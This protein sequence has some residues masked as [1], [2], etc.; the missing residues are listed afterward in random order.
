MP[1]FD[2]TG[3]QSDPMAALDYLS[4]FSGG[5]AEIG[6]SLIG[7]GLGG[8]PGT[9]FPLPGGPAT[10]LPGG[11]IT[12]GGT[13][14]GGRLINPT[15]NHPAATHPGQVPHGRFASVIYPVSLST[16]S[17]TPPTTNW[18]A[19][20]SA[21][22]LFAYT[23]ATTSQ[24]RARLK[25]P[26]GS[27]VDF[28]SAFTMPVGN[29][30]WSIWHVT[31]FTDAWG[32]T[33]SYEYDPTYQYLTKIHYPSGMVEKWSWDENAGG[34]TLSRITVTYDLDGDNVFDEAGNEA[35]MRWGMEFA[36]QGQLTRPFLS[37]PLTR[38]FYP[39]SPYVTA[40]SQNE[41]FSTTPVTEHRVIELA[42]DDFGTGNPRLTTVYEYWRGTLFGSSA[43][44]SDKIATITCTSINGRL[45]VTD[46]LDRHG[47]HTTYNY[48]SW[49]S[50]QAV[51]EAQVTDPRGT[52]RTIQFDA[53]AR[54]T[55]ETITPG[56]TAS[57]R[58]RYF[59]SYFASL[60]LSEPSSVYWE[61]VYGS[62]GC[63]CGKPTEVR[64]PGVN[65]QRIE[66]WTWDAWGYPLTHTYPNPA[67]ASSASTI[68]ES[69]T[70]DR[71]VD[72]SSPLHSR[73]MMATHTDPRGTWTGTTTW[74]T[75]PGTTQQRPSA[76]VLTSPSVHSVD[77]TT[78]TVA[79]SIA[80][81]SAGR[82]TRTVD[83]DGVAVEYDYL[84]NNQDPGTGKPSTITRLPDGQTGPSVVT[85]FTWDNLG[86]LIDRIDNAGSS[87]ER[88]STFEH[89]V[90][91]RLLASQ[92]V[93]SDV[94]PFGGQHS[95]IH[96]VE[97]LRDRHGNVAVQR[98]RSRNSSDGA[99]HRDGGSATS[100]AREWIRHDRHFDG[101]WLVTEFVD[102]RALDLDANG[103][104]SDAPDALTLEYSYTHYPDGTIA[105]VGLPNGAV[106]V[107]EVDGFGT[108]FRTST[109]NQSA[110]VT[111]AAYMIDSALDVIKAYRGKDS[112]GLNLWT[113][114]NRQPWSGEIDSVVEP[115]LPNAP[116]GYTGSLG[117]ASHVFTRDTLGRTTAEETYDGSTLLA[118][119]EHEYDELSRERRT[120]RHMLGAGPGGYYET[121]RR[122]DGASLLASVEQP[123]GRLTSY[124]YDDLG[125]LNEVDDSLQPTAN[126]LF[127]DYIAGTD[128]ISM[129]RARLVHDVLNGSATTVEYQTRYT[130]D[131]L[132]RLRKIEELGAGGANPP[133][134][135]AFWYYTTGDTE[136]HL[137]WKG[138][139]QPAVGSSGCR[140]EHYLPDALG[141]LVEQAILGTSSQST[142][143]D[144]VLGLVHSDWTD[145]ST[146]RTRLDRYDGVG[147]RTTVHY[148]F[149]GRADIEQRPGAPS[150]LPTAVSQE[151]TLVA[152]Y[153]AASRIASLKHGYPIS[154][155]MPTTEMFWSGSD[156]L[157]V[158]QFPNVN[159]FP[160][161][162]FMA[163]REV[164]DR[165]ARGRVTKASTYTGDLGSLA[166]LD[167]VTMD[168]D[169]VGRVHAEHY[170]FGILDLSATDIWNVT[171]TYDATLKDRRDSLTYQ[172]GLQMTMRWDA[173]G[174][175]EGLDW[176]PGGSSQL[177][178]DYGHFGSQTS[179]RHL[180]PKDGATG[181]FIDTEYAF[182][183]YGRMSRIT[184]S[185][186]GSN[187]AQIDD[188]Q[189][190][191]DNFGN[192][193]QELYN[194]PDGNPNT[195]NAGDEFH[196]DRFHRLQEAI[197]GASAIP[198][199]PGTDTF[200][201]KLTYGLDPAGNRTTVQ[202]QNGGGSPSTETYTTVANRYTQVQPTIPSTLLYDGRGNLIFDGTHYYVFDFKDRL[203]E[204]WQLV[205][206]EVPAEQ[207][208]LNSAQAFEPLTA[209]TALLSAAPL[210]SAR[211]TVLA[212][213]QAT[214]R[215]N[216]DVRR[217]QA[218]GVLTEPVLLPYGTPIQTSAGIRYSQQTSTQ[219]TSLQ[220]IAL[221]GY[222]AY[223]RRV[224][225]LVVSDSTTY[226]HVYDGWREIQ[227]LKV[228]GTTGAK[229]QFK[230]FVWGS[231]L[232]E[233]TAY[234]RNDAPQGQSP[235]WTTY[236]TTQCGHECALSVLSADGTLLE[237]VTFDPYGTASIFSA[238]GQYVGAD[239]ATLL[240]FL[241]KA[242]HNE[243]EAPLTLLRNR[244]YIPSIGRFAS[245]D[246]LGLWFDSTNR[247]SGYAYGGNSPVVFTDPFGLQGTATEFKKAYDKAVSS[248]EIDPNEEMSLDKL[249]VLLHRHKPK[250][251]ILDD[252]GDAIRLQQVKWELEV[253]H[254][255]KWIGGPYGAVF[256]GGELCAKAIKE[257]DKPGEVA[258]TVGFFAAI[259]V[260]MH[261]M[262]ESGDG[263]QID[264]S[265]PQDGRTTDDPSDSGT[266]SSDGEQ[267]GGM[268]GEGGPTIQSKTMGEGD[269]WRIDVENP[270]PG[271]RPGQVHI[272]TGKDKWLYEPALDLFRDKN[273]V[274]APSRI[275]RLLQ[276][277]EIRRAINKALKYLGGG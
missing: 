205:A 154:G 195:T 106:R 87:L 259:W 57:E 9:S 188:Y 52:V 139:S 266:S 64:S 238:T 138:T 71:Q 26:T 38:I 140:E 54:K 86:R 73:S 246:P 122:F 198:F 201:Q 11:I 217:M 231:R 101:D 262:V 248:G 92:A 153:D 76:Y 78:S 79:T 47:Y 170:D 94:D 70:W 245:V 166:L 123:G 227:E 55:R 163:S 176:N 41:L 241:W 91:G 127:Y 45:R 50:N 95:I 128:S 149:A 212:G 46:L 193:S 223:N 90:F 124:K 209:K 177:L 81:N 242:A 187:P 16:T 98:E 161:H 112:A 199:T 167:A 116:P 104:L 204:I 56:S 61:Y 211:E 10:G 252:P 129:R 197:L 224:G 175:M 156:Q 125:R 218:N 51:A 3:V 249:S 215:V 121:K 49:N 31:G 34:G 230:E 206:D 102:R 222:D 186:V 221:Y 93:V 62:P 251:G 103:T 89:D 152:A 65:G 13:G 173:I 120:K 254:W 268:L 19:E 59:D 160:Y 5:A 169:S 164:F 182:E 202:T 210:H 274:R 151:N 17:G 219:T 60:G 99:P 264:G 72:S 276:D 111:D 146:C 225:R 165:D 226:L 158:R 22:Q 82:V 67:S 220:L 200:V 179:W 29:D 137:N 74:T 132:G 4:V 148:D 85:K 168:E 213:L 229:S 105:Q 216:Q 162:S 36:H 18:I 109:V 235:S 257:H 263:P 185:R 181:T 155:V 233:L 232:D 255:A 114:I 237:R 133:E 6:T 110:T 1:T 40:N 33:K 107:Y 272:Q 23:D 12:R 42:Y 131:T 2:V 8:E 228:D 203:S 77:S 265:A 7:A 253:L 142:T 183:N 270:N 66:N 43:Q 192:L 25:I 191:Y 143:D 80:W 44:P 108:L 256:G 184:D 48:V 69:W 141:R 178:A 244:H 28:E 250:I 236:H 117:G 174:R 258:A 53:D 35:S 39:A 159:S 68:V 100:S 118:K 75:I 271:Q 144:I 115:I 275:Q 145:S 269:N 194:R 32:H 267:P 84:V 58:P 214:P 113:T 247:G 24:P 88:H 96:R 172:G 97:C 190:V 243:S 136:W 208:Q 260:A 240:P 63:G 196:Y 150:Y 147:N 234:R 157:L 135:Q 119:V 14:D 207:T 180:K 261:H 21:T 277:P 27:V 130:W 83:G 134:T 273:A 37:C 30:T 15:S 20:N 189:F 239:S 126:A 171:S